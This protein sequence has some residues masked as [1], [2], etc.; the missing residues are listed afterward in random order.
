M[1]PWPADK[2][3]LRPLSSLVPAARNARMHSDAQIDQIIASITEWGW[4][5]PVLVDEAGMVIAG[6]GRLLA[7]ERMGLVEVPVIIARGWSEM[8]KRAYLIADNKLSENASWHQEFLGLELH[9]LALAGFDTL[10]TGFTES[11]IEA[12]GM[13]DNSPLREWVGMPEF[14]QNEKKA[15]RTMIVHFQ[16][17]GSFKTF[18]GLVDQQVTDKTKFIWFPPVEDESYVQTQYRAAAQ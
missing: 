13:P 4:T 18:M 12:I 14:E 11:E 5:M 8:Q 10:L 15:Y 7:A 9:E 6:H 16:D 2:I 17:E 3:E 1:K